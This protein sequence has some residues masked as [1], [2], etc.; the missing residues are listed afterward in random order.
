[1]SDPDRLGLF[2]YGSLVG[3]ASA[4]RTLGRPVEPAAL[5]SLPGWRRRWSQARDNLTCEKTF[6]RRSDGSLF[7]HVLGL[8]L[9][10]ADEEAEAP[11]GVVLELTA[12][13][14][15]RLDVREMRYDRVD[16]TD[17]IEVPSGIARVFTY[18]AKEAHFAPRPPED[19]VILAS[20]A[21]A[22]ESAFGALGSGE[23]ELYLRTTGPPPVEVVDAVLVRDRIPPGN[24]RDW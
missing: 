14:L 4:E 3:P 11:N 17:R 24:P 10:P 23:Q 9:E 8:N 2:A 21:G 1:V 7:R 16:V 15:R 22:V 20:Y 12:D 18:A 19:T 13:E 6:A 5:A